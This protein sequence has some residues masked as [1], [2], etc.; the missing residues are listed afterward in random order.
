M[1]GK[2][3]KA[4]RLGKRRRGA[5]GR[6]WTEGGGGGVASR[7]IQ[8]PWSADCDDGDDGQMNEGVGHDP[9]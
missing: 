3:K 1:D 9:V 5:R 8:A 7:A 6:R 2:N 4:K